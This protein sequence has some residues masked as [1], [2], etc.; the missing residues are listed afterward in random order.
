MD[1]SRR[2]S[3]ALV[4]YCLF[5]LCLVPL[6]TQAGIS[7]TIL[8]FGTIETDIESGTAPGGT[9]N[10]V[11]SWGPISNLPVG[12][13][14]VSPLNDTVLVVSAGNVGLTFP[15]PYQ[16]PGSNWSFESSGV[17]LTPSGCLA[18]VDV[19]LPDG[20]LYKEDDS[21][22]FF[23]EGTYDLGQVFLGQNA[24]IR[25]EIPLPGVLD[26]IKVEN[27]PFSINVLGV[28]T[29]S[30]AVGFTLTSSIMEHDFLV[31][32]NAAPGPRPTNSGWMMQAGMDTHA[33]V[34]PTGL[35][36][37]A[38]QIAPNANYDMAFPYG[39]ELRDVDWTIDYSDN[40]ISSATVEADGG[41]RVTY[42]SD[43][44]DAGAAQRSFTTG[45]VTFELADD[46]ALLGAPDASM[47]SDID[48]EFDAYE[49]GPIDAD[50]VV[51]VPG[52]K[53]AGESDLENLLP[54]TYLLAGRIAAGTHDLVFVTFPEQEYTEG[55]G[56]YAGLTF[57]QGELTGT[58]FSVLM[59]CENAPFSASPGTKIY[60]RG[61]G[62]SGCLDASQASITNLPPLMLY[63]QYETSLTKF[64]ITL[65]DNK[66]WQDSAIDGTLDLPFPSDVSFDFNSMELDS[67]GSPGTA[68]IETFENTLA[69]WNRSFK[70]RG[71]EFRD[72]L[73]GMGD[74]VASSC[75]TPL[76]TLW[77]Q[78]SNSVPEL[79]KALLVDT[80]FA[81]DGDIIDNEIAA[82][83][84][85]ALQSWPFTM[86]KMYYSAWD[87]GMG[88][89]G[90]TVVVGDMKLP[91]WG[92]TPVVALYDTGVIPQV[93]DGRPYAQSPI[94]D[95]DPDRNGFPAGISTVAEYLE[96]EDLRPLVK[97]S[98][99][100]V[101]PLDYRVKYN[102]VSRRFATAAGEEEGRDL[103]VLE[104]N[105]SVRGITKSDTEV[106]FAAEFGIPAINV[107]SL[108]EDLADPALQALMMPIKDNMNSVNGAL[109]GS[110]GQAIRGGMEDLTR[111][112]VTD[113]VNQIR[114]AAMNAEGALNAG[115]I[116]AIETLI[117]NRIGLL[118]NFLKNELDSDTGPIIGK[119][120]EVLT[121]LEN[122]ESKIE[123]LDP[124]AVEDILVALIELAG[125]DPTGVQQVL[126][127]VEAARQYI[128]TE[129]I[130]GQLKPQLEMLRTE[131]DNLGTIPEIQDLV[132]GAEFV[133]AMAEVR[134]ELNNL[135][136]ELKNNAA[137]VRNLDPEMVNTRVVNTIYNAFFFQAV[138]QIVA[139]IFEPLKMQIQNILNGFFDSL[140]NQVKA[141]IDLVG[142]A[143]D[144]ITKPIN[145]VTGVAAAKLSGYAVFGGESL[146]RLHVD[147]DFSLKIPDEDFSFMG[148][149]DME[150]FKNNSNGAVCGTPAG[151]ESI[152]VKI[153]VYDIPLRFPRSK[154]RADQ[155]ALMLR[156]N[157]NAPDDPFFVSD[158]A[159]LIE[160]SGSLDFEAV[161]VLSPSFA[162]GVGLN[163]NYIAFSGGIVFN[164]VSMRGG[165]FLG[166]TCSGV[167]I[168]EAIDPEVGGLFTQQVITGIYSFGEA[169]IPIVDYSCL[170]R[171]GATAGAG[172][173]YFVEG[174]SYG[175]KLTAGVYGEGLCLV[176]V[177]G[178]LVLIGG[179]EAG[180]YFFRG[181]GWVAGGI[182]FCEPEEWFNVDDVW[183]D[184]W[185]ATCVL[186]LEATY[187][188]G[189]SVDHSAQ[190]KL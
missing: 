158:I 31:E 180:G 163:E 184:K 39:H 2:H 187:K 25:D 34:T 50:G 47:A 32:F 23:S 119:I 51:Y 11:I 124:A 170:L 153:A 29:F 169:A 117:N 136:D 173:W 130:N 12:P 65:L 152:K 41:V 105:S 157:Q 108:L 40:S 179:K 8:R 113:M 73:N 76:R 175:G 74:P 20:L 132:D 172:F 72:V 135:I 18:S 13:L 64:N 178:K 150:R 70:F 162:A 36:F 115:E 167:E 147:A 159:G 38:H 92:A 166:R 107:S 182:G 126:G 140:N 56:N 110:L 49:I 143:L 83:A 118:E 97:A 89:N 71:M 183:A 60:V 9:F 146:D 91:F 174:P 57:D 112:T 122:V 141:Y 52:V 160:T 142:G 128:I 149:L 109:S 156:L 114:S 127:D 19:V 15:Q 14:S 58:D 85:N 134:T 176:S 16:A 189:W 125:A 95:I 93:F 55:F 7:Q 138:N 101:I 62:V 131:L 188:N 33:I 185:C 80:N 17:V 45:P 116:T 67:C 181:T 104:I 78:S 79:Q 48:L 69:Y 129:L 21:D 42:A 98:F 148:S 53:T 111:P 177:R 77:T 151:A 144:D 66:Q 10:G 186:W 43:P 22:F 123:T 139:Q 44:C 1:S 133:D 61:G 54:S 75:G 37:Q 24:G 102:N 68:K 161:K 86:R 6:G 82:E 96:E 103:V 145:D 27:E 94:V 190:C 63:G 30:D 87:G 171:V 88:I 137:S 28:A 46:W 164:Q 59:A 35:Q 120:D 106:L 3:C 5:A 81:G 155:I 99:A 4:L 26:R 154:L 100:N 84:G 165:I 168:L 121:A 90:K